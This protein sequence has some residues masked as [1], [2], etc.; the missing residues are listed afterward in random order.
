[1]VKHGKEKQKIGSHKKQCERP[2]PYV[3]AAAVNDDD[4][5]EDGIYNSLILEFHWMILSVSL[6]L[7]QQ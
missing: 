6:F 1:M 5:D 3:A 7:S 2:I 4:D